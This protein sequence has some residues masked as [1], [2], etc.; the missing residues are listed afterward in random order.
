MKKTPLNIHDWQKKYLFVENVEEKASCNTRKSKKNE[1]VKEQPLQERFFDDLDQAKE[2]ARKESEE[3]FVQHVN[4]TPNGTYKVEDWLDGDNT[5]ISYQGGDLLEQEQEEDNDF[6]NPGN[7]EKQSKERQEYLKKFGK[8]LPNYMKEQEVGNKADNK[9]VLALLDAKRL[10]H[11]SVEQAKQDPDNA[12]P[13]FTDTVAKHC[14]D[15]MSIFLDG[16]K[17]A[18]YNSPSY[19]LDENQIQS[20]ESYKGER[21][22]IEY[23]APEGYYAIGEGDVRGQIA[24]AYFNSEEEAIEHAQLE[25]EGFLQS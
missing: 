1:T 6:I 11:K 2:Y 16:D 24:K 25:I 10:A 21:F 17:S 23:K 22:R 12:N 3:G 4:K 19:Y 20:R 14:E 15:I 5:V 13:N 9:L 18:L 8:T 7:T